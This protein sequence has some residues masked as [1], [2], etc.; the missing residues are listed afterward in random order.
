MQSSVT[1]TETNLETDPNVAASASAIS[2]P[3]SPSPSPSPPNYEKFNKI[4]GGIQSIVTAAGLVIAGC[5]A[6]WRYSDLLENQTAIASLEKQEAQ[7]RTEKRQAQAKVIL[8]VEVS[9]Q[10]IPSG[11]ELHASERWVVVE[12]SVRNAGNEDYF[13]KLNKSTKFYV[14]KAISVASDGAQNYGKLIKLQFDYPDMTINGIAVKPSSEADK[15]RTIQRIEEPGLYI[16]RFAASTTGEPNKE[17]REYSA[18]SFF[19][20]R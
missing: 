5:W 4:S 14:A 18:Q 8:H 10:Q 3:P 17:S 9:A 15:Y 11:V 20:V 19:Y 7:A 13:L 12:L 16:V 1:A 6:L 2:P